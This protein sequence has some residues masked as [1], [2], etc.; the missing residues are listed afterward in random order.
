MAGQA[1]ATPVPRDNPGDPEKRAERRAIQISW[2]TL[3]GRARPDAGGTRMKWTKLAFLALSGLA[4]GCAQERDPINKVQANALAKSF[5]VGADLASPDDDPE[6]YFRATV[7]DVGYGDG[8]G[9]FTS[10]NAQTVSRIKWQVTE[11]LLLGRLTY[12]RIDGADGHGSATTNDGIIVAAFNISSHFDIRRAYNPTT[13]EEQ[14]VIEENTLDR[15]WFQREFFRVDWAANLATDAYDFDSLALQGLNGGVG[16]QNL[17]FY[18]SDPSDPNAPVFDAEAGYFDVTNKLF[19]SPKVLDTPYGKYPACFFNGEVTGGVYPV[20]SCDP[21]EVTVR[22]S[23]RKVVDTDYEPKDWTGT[24]FAIFGAFYEERRGWDQEY[25]VVDANWHRFGS[26]YNIWEKSHVDVACN[27]PATTPVGGDPHRDEDHDGT[28]DECAAADPGSRCDAFTRKCTVPYAQRTN[29]QIPW[30]FGPTGDADLFK[31]TSDATSEWDLALR[32]AV[33]AGRL[34]ECRRTGGKSIGAADPAA[35]D[36]A[37]PQGD[38]AVRAAVPEILFLCHNPV[39][40]DDRAGCGGE[41]LA[42]RL[43][44]LRYN[45]VNAIP[46]PQS[47]SPWGVMLDGVDPLTGEKVQASINVWD[48]VTQSAAQSSVDVIRWMNGEISQDDIMSGAYVN[49]FA[50]DGNGAPKSIHEFRTMTPDEVSARLAS[51]SPA[52][53]GVK[54]PG[55]DFPAMSSKQIEKLGAAAYQKVYGPPVDGSPNIAARFNAAVGSP[56]ETKLTNQQWMEIS[57]LDPATQVDAQALDFASPLR[58]NNFE[59]QSDLRRLREQALADRGYCMVE[60]PEPTAFVGMAAVMKD[61]FPVDPKADEKAVHERVGKMREYMRRRLHYGVI[62]HEMGHSIGL[63][64]NFVGSYDAF[65]FMPQYWQLRTHNGEIA[66]TCGAL[67]TDG[68]KC[69]GPRW[70]DPVSKEETDGLLWMWQHTTVMDYPGDVSQDTLGLGAYDKAAARFFYS[71]ALDVWSTPGQECP[72]VNGSGICTTAAKKTSKPATAVL[73]KVG[74]YGGIGGPWTFQGNLTSDSV[75][76]SQFQSKFKLIQNCH[77]STKAQPADWDEATEGKWSPVFDGHVV[78][79]TECDQAPVDVVDYRDLDAADNRKVAGSGRIRWPHMFATDYSADIGNVAVLR[80]DNG[81]DPYEQFN[82][83]IN[84]Y[85]NRHIFD[86]FRRGRQSFSV[87]AAAARAQSRF[88]DKM[89]NIVQGFALYHDYLLRGLS[90]ETGN[91]YFAAYESWDGMLKPNALAASLAFDMFTRVLTRPQPGGHALSKTAAGDPVLQSVEAFVSSTDAVLT[92]P[93]GSQTYTN[94]TWGFGARRLNNALSNSD[95]AFDVQWLTSAGS[96]YD[97]VH[98]IYHLTESSNRFLDVSLSDFLD[99]RYR[100]LSFVNLYPDGYRRLVATAMTGDTA[101]LGASVAS[102][103]GVGPEIDGKQWPKRPL[104]FTSWWLPD[105]PQVC[106]PDKD[107]MACTDPTGTST[108]SSNAPPHVIPVDPQVGFEVQKFVVYYS[109]LYLPEN[110]KHDWVD[111]FRI[112]AAGGDADPLLPT[113]NALWF[114]D[115]ESGTLYI[116]HRSGTEVIL[117]KTVE[118][119]VAARMLAWANTLTQAAYEV[120]SV[121]PVTGQ[122]HV[123]MDAGQPVLKGMAKTCDD[124]AACA[125]LRN[126]KA[127]ID[128]TRQTAATFGFPAPEPKGVDFNH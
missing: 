101:L 110:W 51:L 54:A 95:G 116:A 56:L 85:E 41:G 70:V 77:P 27:T 4:L 66:A 23:F 112:Y 64:H 104:G 81:A 111:Q 15:P 63:R 57:G 93:E 127:L 21:T 115:P 53:P 113:D 36:G 73:S 20:G 105:G 13:G 106:F 107:A 34:T 38:D 92:L 61:K 29:R 88:H 46:T 52:P 62:L 94:G 72:T 121:D 126:Y 2:R 32:R 7:I 48:S 5:F 108:F 83:L 49:T 84:V 82:Y 128:F 1:L 86:N 89:R 79:A 119:G 120:D 124:S 33:A 39:R 87:R 12:Q 102:L 24:R 6:F 25:G 91:N 125:Q 100:N 71:D 44:D 18:L 30:Y 96:Y 69:V 42:P 98:S 14:N 80:H 22:L 17:N 109:L 122:V 26:F 9:L 65:N 37:F 3:G 74:N 10:A 78:L 19:A 50:V 117:G 43:G 90:Q 76:Y 67:V 123:T 103:D 118:R 16:Y 99:G 59:H 45:F 75:H 60:E 28:E 55:A 58:A 97:K 68:A 11:K 8:N 114:S 35:C 31:W 47:G 40:A